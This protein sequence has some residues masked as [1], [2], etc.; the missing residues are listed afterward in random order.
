MTRILLFWAIFIS[1]LGCN[2]DAALTEEAAKLLSKMNANI[3]V[4][5]QR[6]STQMLEMQMNQSPALAPYK[7]VMTKFFERYM[8]YESLRPEMIRMYTDAYTLEE[9]KEINA[10]YSSKVGKKTLE[11][12]PRLVA[13]SGQIAAAKVEDNLDELRA[14]IKAESKRLQKSSH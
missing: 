5:L 11:L 10:F 7:D 13:Q 3:R 8:S 4:A 2:A 14:M 1:A 12:M 9:L 6:S